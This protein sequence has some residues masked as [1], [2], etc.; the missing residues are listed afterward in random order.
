MQSIEGIF[1]DFLDQIHRQDTAY[2]KQ[3]EE[4]I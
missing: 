3:K 1:P 4:E 2:V